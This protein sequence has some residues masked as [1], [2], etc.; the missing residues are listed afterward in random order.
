MVET[1]K[2]W[3]FTESK[4]VFVSR[5]GMPVCSS[6]ERQKS[7]TQGDL[8]AFGISGDSLVGDTGA[9]L[10]MSSSESAFNTWSVGL[11]ATLDC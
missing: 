9:V 8:T 10:A 11:L 6:T 4:K 5:A 3:F 2:T 7:N 1:R